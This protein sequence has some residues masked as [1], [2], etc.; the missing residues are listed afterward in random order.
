VQTGINHD[1]GAVKVHNAAVCAN[2]LGA[3]QQGY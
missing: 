2:L 3:A 1:K